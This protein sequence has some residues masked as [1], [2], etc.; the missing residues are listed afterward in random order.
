MATVIEKEIL[1]LLKSA[2]MDAHDTAAA[3]AI[4]DFLYGSE[5]GSSLKESVKDQEY[6]DTLTKYTAKDWLNVLKK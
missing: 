3:V 1:G 6:L 5:D 2:E 4:S